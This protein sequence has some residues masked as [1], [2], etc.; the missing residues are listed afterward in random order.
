MSTF[1]EAMSP[2]MGRIISDH[3]PHDMIAAVLVASFFAIV[4]GSALFA[5]FGVFV[6]Q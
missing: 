5:N 3:V 4:F 1:C 6:E 2:F